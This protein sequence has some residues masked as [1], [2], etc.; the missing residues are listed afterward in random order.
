MY[1]KKHKVPEIA[2]TLAVPKRTVY[3]W[4]SAGQWDDMLGGE[5]ALDCVARRYTLLVGRDGKADGDLKEM[6]RLLDHMVR[7]RE[8]QVR[9]IEAANEARDEG[10]PVVGG[11]TRRPKK[12]RGKI[13]KNDVS[14]LTESDFREKFHGRFYE[15]QHELRQAKET[16]RVRNILKSRQIGATWYFAQ[17][18]FEDACLSGDNQIFLSATRRQADVFRAYIVA[19]V[20]EQ[21]DIELK[22]KDEI[23]LHTAHGP[24]TLYFLSNN[25]KSAQ[26]Y[27][28]HVYIDEYFWITKFDELYKVASAMAA[29]KKWRITLFSTPSAVT[30]EAYDLWTGDRFNKR[31]SRQ[32]K[33]KEFP[34]FEAMQRGVVCPDKV[35]RKVITIKDAE[36]GGCDLFD[37]EDLNLQYSTDEFRNLFMC[38]FV[39]DLQ[40]V[41]RLHNLEACYGD[42]DEWTDF[43]PDA[44]RPFGNLPVW[45]GYDPSR[46][47]DDASFVI[48]APPLQSGGM[49]RVLAR[50]KWVDKSYTWQ[51][52]RIKELT[53]QFNFVHIGIDVTGPGIGVFESVQAFFP[54]A[55]PI[56][57]G[58]QTKTTL[59]L[60]A[61]DVI[62]SGR[63]QWDASLTDIAHA[64]LT[65][66]QGTTGNGMIT[67][68]AGRTE[69]T[70]HADVAWAIMHALA[71][72]PLNSQHQ[73][74]AVVAFGK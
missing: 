65:I 27:H 18:A 34:S 20:K 24:A 64:F 73:R 43:N 31:W 41:F 19:I 50:Y 28:G 54:A 29:H 23:V 44:A 25:S 3:Q 36:A 68:S 63:I 49:F 32:A 40:A 22:G 67:Y 13:I 16:H 5:S 55:M 60:K 30:H 69:A 8:M 59:V 48:L 61:K 74:K 15:Y 66:R 33:R 52:Q 17:E 9:E 45:G 53:Q 46:N 56:T 39:D 70:G 4:R 6:D 47:R 37:F 21:F 62:E 35:W 72:E 14:H 11:R 51:A 71:N 57:Y 2:A 12:K 58:V 10:R 38:E 26:S 42:M 1:L 7:L